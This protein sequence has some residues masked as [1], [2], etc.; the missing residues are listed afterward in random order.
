[1]PTRPSFPDPP[2]RPGMVGLGLVIPPPQATKHITSGDKA[3]PLLPVQTQKIR[4]GTDISRPEELGRSLLTGVPSSPVLTSHSGYTES[5]KGTATTSCNIPLSPLLPPS[6]QSTPYIPQIATVIASGQAPKSSPSASRPNLKRFVAL[7]SNTT[8][9]PPETSSHRETVPAI[10]FSSCSK[11]QGLSRS[12]MKVLV[13][14]GRTTRRCSHHMQSFRGVVSSTSSRRNSSSSTNPSKS[15]SISTSSSFI[16]QTGPTS[17][18]IAASKLVHHRRVSP[19]GSTRLTPASSVEAISVASWLELDDGMSLPGEIVCSSPEPIDPHF[20]TIV[21]EDWED[22][23]SQAYLPADLTI[24]RNDPSGV[25]RRLF[26]HG[27]IVRFTRTLKRARKAKALK[28]RSNRKESVVEGTDS[29]VESWSPQVSLF[30]HLAQILSTPRPPIDTLEPKDSTPLPVRQI[31]HL[32]PDMQ[33]VLSGLWS[34]CLEDSPRVTRKST[35]SRVGPSSVMLGESV[36]IRHPRCGKGLGQMATSDY[37]RAQDDEDDVLQMYEDMSSCPSDS[38]SSG[39]C[40]SA[41]SSRLG[42]STSSES[43]W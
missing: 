19:A 5:L 35:V 7:L 10:P 15:L 4:D 26:R 20:T 18:P 43:T 25:G 32:D 6:F 27:A 23:V 37:G 17:L 39:L 16:S 14:T 34:T 8:C 9:V 11:A 38:R 31:D 29:D 3:F 21:E 40:S 28:K 36:A 2:S 12:K 30:P 41:A 24:E 42:S 33:D 22:D 1:M 13:S